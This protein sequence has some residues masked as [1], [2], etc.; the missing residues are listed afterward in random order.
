MILVWFMYTKIR[1]ST[2]H[3]HNHTSSS[4]SSSPRLPLGS[5]GVWPFLGETFHFIS[6]AYNSDQPDA[7]TDNRRRMYG[8]VFKSHLFGSPTIVSTDAEVSRVIMQ[9]DAKTFVPSYPKSLMELMGKSSIL[10]INGALQRRI[11]G[12]IASFFKSP[13]LKAQIAT[14]M[15]KYVVESMG[16]WKQNCPVYIQD[17]AKNV[18]FNFAYS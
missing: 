11:H 17:E 4:S 7:F 2:N 12:L 5:L 3:N 8:T 9:S 16:E 13:N 10:L 18:S 1:R 14:D 6:S 15:D